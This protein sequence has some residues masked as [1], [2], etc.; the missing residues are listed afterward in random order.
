M[1]LVTKNRK[2]Y[3]QESEF[4]LER[5]DRFFNEIIEESARE[6]DNNLIE[7]IK[8][9]V[10]RDVTS[11]D[12]IEA[13]A[14]FDLII[15]YTNDKTD[16]NNPDLT[17]LSAATMRRKLY[18]EASK[19]RGYHYKNT[20]GDYLSLVVMLIEEG[21][22]DASLLKAY[23]EDE[24]RQAGEFIQPELDRKFNFPGILALN[25]GYLKKGYKR[26]TLELPQER[27]LTMTLYLMQ[28]E[29]KDVRM[30][31]V[32]EAYWVVSNHYVGIATPTLMNSGSPNG[33]LSSCHITTTPDDLNGIMDVNKQIA[34]FSQNGAGIGN[35]LGFLRSEGSWIRGFKGRS[36]GVLHPSRLQSVIA[37]YVNQLGKIKAYTLCRV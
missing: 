1:T 6:Y 11:R 32:K 10:I 30:E 20:Y 19:N 33:T 31:L 9:L 29:D 21:I 12:K 15:R 5:F 36:T 4:M 14:L 35:Y 3:I 25:N 17:Y 8:K 26:D 34:K 2:S 27:F 28:L 22:Y 37:E 7:E 24:L 16:K 18:K 13:I 23:T